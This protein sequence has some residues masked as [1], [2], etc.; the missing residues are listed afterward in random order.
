M[1]NLVAVI[2]FAASVACSCVVRA[3]PT[4]DHLKCHRVKD[5]AAKTTYTADLA[6]L[7]PEPGCLI[8]VPA[9]L[10]CVETTKTNVNR[11]PTRGIAT[12]SSAIRHP[13]VGQW[14]C[15]TA[16]QCTRKPA[17]ASGF[18]RALVC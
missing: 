6:G 11:V 7:A 17:L 18:R 10:V 16:A 3:Q 8:K 14:S 2:V 4:P 9:K 12:V 1:R 5:E 15:T 13:S